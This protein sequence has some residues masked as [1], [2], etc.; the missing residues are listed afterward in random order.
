MAAQ[1]RVMLLILLYFGLMVGGLST[2]LLDGLGWVAFAV[3]YIGM[4]SGALILW[5]AAGGALA[6]RQRLS[7]ATIPLVVFGAAGAALIVVGL[8]GAQRAVGWLHVSALD[9]T[10]SGLVFGVF[11]QQFVVS[12]IE[13]FAFRGVIQ[14][15]LCR[16]AGPTRGLIGASVLFGLFHLPNILFQGVTGLHIPLT[17][18]VLTLMGAVF[19]W[20]YLRTGQHL[21]LPIALHFGWNTACFGLEAINDFSFSGPRWL[22]GVAA[23][24]PESGVL[25]A[26]ALIVLGVLV[27]RLTLRPLHVTERPAVAPHADKM[28]EN[29]AS[30]GLPRTL[31]KI[32]GD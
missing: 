19:G 26:L 25:G 28:K 16:I 3:Y 22:T 18:M 12:A 6:R 14:T 23:W 2:M 8:Y 7:G 24:F 5:Y 31:P 30:G 1:H 27:H 32:G 4:P 10:V 21:A 17:V 13:E 11:A 15:L 9:W 29:P 20:G